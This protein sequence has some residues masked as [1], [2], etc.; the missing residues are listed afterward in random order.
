MTMEKIKVILAS[1]QVIFREGIHF[2]LSGEEDF[3]VASE[4]TENNEVFG[5]IEGGPANIVILSQGDKKSDVAEVTRRIKQNYPSVAVILIADKGAGEAVFPAM[6]SGVS[7]VISS[8]ADPETMVE[9]IRKAAQGKLPVVENLLV[10][11]LAGRALAEFQ[12]L[13]TLNERLGIAMAQLSKKES[14]VLT[15]IASGN[16]LMQ[17]AS[18]LSLSEDWAR[19]YLRAVLQKLVANDR[20]RALIEKTQMSLPSL[21]NLSLKGGQSAEYLTRAEFEEF[22]SKINEAFRSSSIE[23]PR[24]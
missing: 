22:K 10:P 19:D 18:R 9:E 6:V 4:T 5:L 7:A 12:D 14:E 2:I 24:I 8:D 23:K 3:E 11:A 17:T 15:S 16:D 20:T 1:P 13:A 21:Y